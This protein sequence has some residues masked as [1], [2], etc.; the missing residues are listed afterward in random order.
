MTP[1]EVEDVRLFVDHTTK[2]LINAA[3]HAPNSK[4]KTVEDAQK[5]LEDHKEKF[6]MLELHDVAHT[7]VSY[8]KSDGKNLVPAFLRSGKEGG[9]YGKETALEEVPALVW[10]DLTG[11][12]PLFTS[13]CTKK[14]REDFK[15][16]I[17]NNESRTRKEKIV[18]I[19]DAIDDTDFE[20]V[21]RGYESM[22]REVLIGIEEKKVD[23]DAK[24]AEI[25]ADLTSTF[26]DH[27]KNPEPIY[28]QFQK[29][30]FENHQ[31][32]PAILLHE[33]QR[34]CGPLLERLRRKDEIKK[35]KGEQLP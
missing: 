33:F 16:W 11:K 17:Q 7:I 23:T 1:Q 30:I 26:D 6:G 9:P 4:Y 8:E 3:L 22:L 21:R 18:A 19:V 25:E 31:K 14:G 2:R 29:N 34:I 35:E 20:S 28:L 10:I 15:E 24:R 13:M 27:L 32:D 5:A 12:G